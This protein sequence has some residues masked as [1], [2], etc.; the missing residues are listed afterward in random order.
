M[1]L[2]VDADDSQAK[3][4]GKVWKTGEAEPEGWTI[5]AT[6]PHPNMSGSPGLYVY[7]TTDCMFDNVVVTQE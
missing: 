7:A 1:K 4:F 6:D 3:I 5:E 2:K